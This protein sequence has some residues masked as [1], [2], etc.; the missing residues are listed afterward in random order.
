MELLMVREMVCIVLVRP[1]WPVMIISD[2]SV[3]SFRKLACIPDLVRQL[4]RVE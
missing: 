1:L 3:F 4:V 2:L